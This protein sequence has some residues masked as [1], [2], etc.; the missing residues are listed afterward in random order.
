MTL[1]RGVCKYS[2]TS[3]ASQGR[4]ETKGRVG[5]FAH[6]D[7]SHMDGPWSRPVMGR[8]PSCCVG[9]STGGKAGVY[10]QAGL[11]MLGGREVQLEGRNKLLSQSR[12]RASS[13]RVT[14]LNL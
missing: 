2:E 8:C 6:S 1:R 14:L 10:H 4:V 12:G 13:C 3:L 9:Q 11:V 5:P 7:S